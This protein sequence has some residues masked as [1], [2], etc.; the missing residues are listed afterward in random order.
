MYDR[1]GVNYIILF[2]KKPII[3]E[4]NLKI[5]LDIDLSGIVADYFNKKNKKMKESCHQYIFGPV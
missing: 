5:D 1:S 4:E 3:L 2:V